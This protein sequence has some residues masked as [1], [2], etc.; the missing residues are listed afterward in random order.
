ME[1]RFLGGASE[2]G[3]SGILMQ[4]GKN[5]ILMDY[6]LKINGHT[7]YPL[8]AGDVDAFILSH[9]HL[10]HCGN[11]PALYRMGMPVA[12]GTAPSLGLAELLIADSIKI[13]RI[14]RTKGHYGKREAGFFS[15]SYKTYN[16]HDPFEFGGYNISFYDA[17]HIP[18]SAVTKI[19]NPVTKRNLVYTGDF[20]LEPQ[21]LHEGAEIVKADTLII[22]STYGARDHPDKSSVV[23]LFISSIKEVI[24]NNGT[25]LIP[26]FAVGRSQEILALLHKNNLSGVT[27]MDGMSRKATEIVLRNPGYIKGGGMLAE[28]VRKTVQISKPYQREEALQGGHIIITTAGMLNG[29]PVLDYITKLNKQSMIFLTGY[30]AEDTN[31]RKL[32]DE[33]PLDI[34]GRKFAVRNPY[35]FFD[36]SA[37]AGQQ[38]LYDYVKGA[39]PEN[40]ILVHG[41]V[42]AGAAFKDWLQTEGFKA[43]TPKVGDTIK[44]DL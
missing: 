2:V 26:A 14:N 10:D 25:A 30:Q 17:G 4:D 24:G 16:Y 29:G 3:R 5:N 23:K 7:E 27:Y 31:G 34:D 19:E 15:K 6:G 18:G 20:K 32:M 39:D 8:P 1:I 41:D 21:T 40:V 38:D 44:V 9:A 36:L 22:E 35:A 28:A 13:N 11:A 37:H 33:K 42:E 43:Q 12:F